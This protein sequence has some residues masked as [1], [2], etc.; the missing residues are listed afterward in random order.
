MLLLKFEQDFNKWRCFLLFLL[1]KFFF[2]HS[3]NKHLIKTKTQDSHPLA[4]NAC[5]CFYVVKTNIFLKQKRMH[6]RAVKIRAFKIEDFNEQDFKCPWLFPML[7][8]SLQDLV[9]LT[10]HYLLLVRATKP[11]VRA[12]K[13][14]LLFKIE[15]LVALTS[16]CPMRSQ[17]AHTARAF[18]LVRATKSQIR[19]TKSILL[20]PSCLLISKIL[21]AYCSFQIFDLNQPL[22]KFFI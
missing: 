7:L 13:S 19:A 10:S 2:L 5:F 16:Q 8:K 12:T 20:A 6:A 3:K 9:A 21:K 22:V 4:N 15:D 14:I 18:L 1:R 11:K 17:A